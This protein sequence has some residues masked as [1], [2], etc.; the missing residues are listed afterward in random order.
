MAQ[1]HL[2]LKKHYVWDP[3]K[4][5]R[6]NV[7][8][9]QQPLVIQEPD[10]TWPQAFE[11]IKTLIE[12]VLGP[13]ALVISHVGSTS[14][15]SLPA[16]PVIDIDLTVPDVLDEASY[17]PALE[18]AGFLFLL[19]EPHFDEHR[20]FALD[21]PH[22]NLHIFARGS[23]EPARHLLFRDWLIANQEDRELYAQTKREA[24]QVTVAKGEDVMAYNG[25]KAAVL[26][27]ILGRIFASMGI[28]AQEP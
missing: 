16:K 25:R 8:R 1:P 4:V 9:V 2:Y 10:P 13:T 24:A 28:E 14:V 21:E 3:S 7:R 23:G 26:R 5:D 12:Q 6:V 18:A 17:V 27:Q 20:L 15:P 22:C 19:R 11:T